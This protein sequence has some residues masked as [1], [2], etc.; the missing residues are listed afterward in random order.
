MLDAIR[1]AV[2]RAVEF[3]AAAQK[4]DGGFRIGVATARSL[5]SA[6]DVASPFAAAIVLLALD[7]VR[8]VPAQLGS[9]AVA[10]LLS[11]REPSG[12]VRYFGAP[13]DPDYDDICLVHSL[14]QDA[15]VELDYRGVARR[16]AGALRADGL[17]PTW[18]GAGRPMDFDPV[19]NV[20]IVRFLD[21]NG[22]ACS[23][24]IARLQE[25]VA[26]WTGD[27]GTLYYPQPGALPWIVCTLPSTL[28][29]RIIGPSRTALRATI[30]GTPAQSL[31]DLA[32]RTRALARLG[33]SPTPFAAPL[34]EAQQSD[35]AWPAG[36]IF[37]AYGFWGSRELTTAIAASALTAIEL[38]AAII[39]VD[40]PTHQ[41][42]RRHHQC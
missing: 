38:G 29:A 14:L 24:T 2:R 40:D 1:E 8:G 37:G 35:G 7:G 12:L 30:A 4:P 10:H 9:R 33:G 3:L 18:V 11:K 36:A 27:E 6:D 39:S 31:L 41:T 16:V 23:R 32:M 34:L 19:V 42:R 25:V 28:R 17:F 5:E 21:R 20:N 15:G 13:I 22:I 26:R